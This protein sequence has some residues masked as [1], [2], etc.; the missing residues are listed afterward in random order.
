MVSY[1]CN[2]ETSSVIIAGERRGSKT[3]EVVLQ[4]NCL[5]VDASNSF[6]KEGMRERERGGGE[7]TRN[8]TWANTLNRRESTASRLFKQIA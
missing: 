5:H 2:L 1:G 6:A 3:M 7:T 8:V 4:C